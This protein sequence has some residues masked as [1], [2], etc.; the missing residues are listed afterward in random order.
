MDK[1]YFILGHGIDIFEEVRCLTA[2]H[3]QFVGQIG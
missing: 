3:D 1:D 2:H